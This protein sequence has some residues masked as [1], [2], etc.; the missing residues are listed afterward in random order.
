MNSAR[1]KLN[2]I[3]WQERHKELRRMMRAKV[4]TAMAVAMTMTRE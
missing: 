4:V 1:K 3:Q 2:T